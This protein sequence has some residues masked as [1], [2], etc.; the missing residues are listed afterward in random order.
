MMPS[1]AK[2]GQNRDGNVAFVPS[3]A[4]QEGIPPTSNGI[5]WNEADVDSKI[6]EWMSCKDVTKFEPYFYTH[7]RNGGTG[8][9]IVLNTAITAFQTQYSEALIATTPRGTNVSTEMHAE[10]P[11]LRPQDASHQVS[12]IHKI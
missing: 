10:T 12:N 9:S 3:T 11:T 6:R 2:Q 5:G 7:I 8:K 1:N 4:E